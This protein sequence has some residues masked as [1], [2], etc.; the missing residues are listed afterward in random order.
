MDGRTAIIAESRLN[1]SAM[2]SGDYFAL[3]ASWRFGSQVQIALG[4]VAG[5][6]VPTAKLQDKSKREMGS[7]FA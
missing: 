6:C 7:A 2:R 4:L 5:N 1:A 3:R